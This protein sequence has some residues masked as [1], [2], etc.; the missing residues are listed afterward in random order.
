MSDSVRRGG[1]LPYISHIFLCA[2][3]NGRVFVPL[4]SEKGYRLY[5]FWSGI[6]YGFLGNYGIV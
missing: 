6:G 2:A 1:V 4:W 3:P 5:P